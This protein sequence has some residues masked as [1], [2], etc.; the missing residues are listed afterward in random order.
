[1]KYISIII[2]GI[3]VAGLTSCNQDEYFTREQYKNVFALVSDDGYNVFTV[4]H[5]LEEP[6]STGYV[7]ASCGGTKPTTEDI[8]ITL[9]S[10]ITSFDEYNK[11]NFDVEISRYARLLPP[12]MYNIDSYSFTIPAGEVKGRMPI[13]VRLEGLSPDSTYFIPVKIDAYSTYEVTPEKSNVLYRPLIKNRYATLETLTNYNLLGFR[14]GVSVI[15]SKRMHPLGRNRVRI[16]AGTEIFEATTTVINSRAIVLEIDEQNRVHIS[17]FKDI[18]VTQVD[19]DP[20]YPNT[21]SIFDDGYKKYRMFLLRY[22]YTIG[23]TTYQMQEELRL[24]FIE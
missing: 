19:N 14:N 12:E 4:V 9:A 10:D 17:P 13:R 16:M 24:E 8:R 21:Y 22:D 2:A 5:D 6:E 1:M 23:T 20:D 3:L 18:T 11:S 7:V 15:G